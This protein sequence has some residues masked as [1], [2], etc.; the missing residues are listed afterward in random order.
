MHMPFD[1]YIP[2]CI[3]PRNIFIKAYKDIQWCSLLIKK[4]YSRDS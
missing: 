2:V 4:K 1:K 3:D